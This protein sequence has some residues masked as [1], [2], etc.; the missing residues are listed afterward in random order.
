MAL[1]SNLQKSFET[2]VVVMSRRQLAEH[3]KAII[4]KLPSPR[5]IS[6]DVARN[7]M[8]F[9]REIVN[10]DLFLDDGKL[11]ISISECHNLYCDDSKLCIS[12][13]ECHNLCRDDSK[14]CISISE[15]H[16]LCR[17]DSKLC[18]YLRMSQP[19]S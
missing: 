2:F 4:S 7:K 8:E 9:L 12:I 5:E 13:S 15:C 3:V 14:L 1:L 6:E 19:L 11:C 10:S 16:N 17:D 18:K